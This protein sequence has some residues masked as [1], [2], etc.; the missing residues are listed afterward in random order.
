M[1]SPAQQ[2][3]S[4]GPAYHPPSSAHLYP[5]HPHPHHH[6][7]SPPSPYSFSS[8]TSTY[9]GN[10]SPYHPPYSPY[11]PFSHFPR[12]PMSQ[13]CPSKGSSP[14]S[15]TSE[16]PDHISSRVG[17][18]VG[19]SQGILSPTAA[20][21]SSFATPPNRDIRQQPAPEITRPQNWNG[22]IP[23]LPQQSLHHHHRFQGFRGGGGCPAT[24]TS[25]AL[26]E[27][28]GWHSQTFP[29]IQVGQPQR[30]A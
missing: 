1:M 7:L 6:Q 3:S 11:S 8:S 25:G 26:G 5:A 27:P 17:G 23:R 21:Y 29:N 15:D 14:T 10:N 22:G 2:Q 13:H 20:N 9:P 16:S 12:T 19:G 24:I 30:P 18:F 28:L 4:H